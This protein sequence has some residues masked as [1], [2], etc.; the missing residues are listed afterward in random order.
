MRPEDVQA[1]V[2]VRIAAWRTAYAGLMPA[3]YLVAMD[4]DRVEAAARLAARLAGGP[5]SLLVGLDDSGEVAGMCSFGAARE[6]PDSGE[7][8]ALNV[9]PRSWGSG[10]GSA[11]LHEAERGLASF[12]SAYLWVVEGNARARRFYERHG[13]RADGGRKIDDTFGTGVTE[14]RYRR[15]DVYQGGASERLI[16]RS[17]ELAAG[18]AGIHHTRGLEQRDRRTRCG[19]RSVPHPARYDVAVADAQAHLRLGQRNGQ[20]SGE[21]EEQL[22]GVVVLVPDELA[23]DPGHLD[24]HLVDPTNDPGVPQV[25]Q[26]RGDSSEVDR[27]AH[28]HNVAPP[29]PQVSW[30]SELW[31]LNHQ[32]HTVAGAHATDPVIRR[33][34]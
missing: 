19:R 24:Q 18:L 27:C 31:T 34:I 5:T 15:P 32:R 16:D 22:V 8:Y 14:L 4:H 13:W 23:L 9:H 33:K 30:R 7:L 21:H 17:G 11:L 6:E 25:G 20:L 29:T 26:V 28:A 3:D 2:D 10:V 1:I 12:P